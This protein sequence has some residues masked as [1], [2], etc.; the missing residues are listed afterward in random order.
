M[1]NNI[2]HEGTDNIVRPHCGF[3]FSDSC[4]YG[5]DS[6]DLHCDECE[7]DFFYEREYDV[8]YST[9]KELTPS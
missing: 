5:G 9:S 1:P 8:T 3:V 2:D 4:D 7:K 6:G